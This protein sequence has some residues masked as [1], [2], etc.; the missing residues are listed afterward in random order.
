MVS[1]NLESHEPIFQCH[2]YRL[3]YNLAFHTFSPI[4]CFYYFQPVLPA[5]T[6][7]VSVMYPTLLIVLPYQP[8]VCLFVFV[9]YV[10][11][12]PH[13]LKNILLSSLCGSESNSTTG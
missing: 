1:L 11:V 4:K 12:I 9:F 10:K 8:F 7:S 2:P 6:T 3:V 5:K 13:L